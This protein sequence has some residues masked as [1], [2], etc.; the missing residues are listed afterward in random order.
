M[1]ICWDVEKDLCADQ[2]YYAKRCDYSI[3]NYTLKIV[4]YFFKRIIFQFFPRQVLC[5]K[6]KRTENGQYTLQYIAF[7]FSGSTFKFT[8]FLAIYQFLMVTISKVTK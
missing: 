3:A 4:K 6:K 8:V 2:L 1:H 5:P 7:T